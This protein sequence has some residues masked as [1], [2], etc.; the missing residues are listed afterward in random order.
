M[1]NNTHTA[2]ADGLR[3]AQNALVELEEQGFSSHF[4]FSLLASAI[5]PG[6]R[7]NFA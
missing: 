1:R 7:Q 2:V 3:A 4:V 5:A 6:Y